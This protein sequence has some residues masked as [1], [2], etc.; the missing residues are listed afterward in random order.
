MKIEGKKALV[1]FMVCVL[2]VA[3]STTVF[4]QQERKIKMDEYKAQLAGFQTREQA[5]NEKI[6]ALQ[7]EITDLK[8]QI[9]DTQSQFD[10]TWND[11]YTMLGTNKAGVDAY[12]TNLDAISGELDGLARLSPEDLFR[13]KEELKGIIKRIEE[14]KAS[15]IALLT[16]MENKLAEI[17]GKVAALKAKMPANIYDLYTVLNGDYLWKIS[18]KDNIYG[19]PYQWI[20]IYCVN[21]DQIKDANLI[22]PEQIFKIARGVGENEYLVV[23]GEYL[24]KIAGLAK[25]F[26]DP[27]KWTKLYEA[28]KDIITDPSLIYP[29]QV[30]TIPKQ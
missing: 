25:V 1:L 11:I 6:N 27:T 23:K 13:R 14:A 15:K 20:R 22:F 5:A 16:E 19:D 8:K 18:K 29:H 12:R 26:N 21:K 17:D 30:L 2:L 4:G 3:F 24:F 9:A 7:A 10:G 28:N